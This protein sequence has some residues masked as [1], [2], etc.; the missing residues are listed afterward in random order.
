MAIGIAR[1]LTFRDMGIAV[2]AEPS[3]GRFVLGAVVWIR[4]C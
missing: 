2:I 1:Y 3:D 4:V